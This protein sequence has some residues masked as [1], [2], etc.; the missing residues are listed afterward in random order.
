[1]DIGG[2]SHRKWTRSFSVVFCFLCHLVQR[3][4]FHSPPMLHKVRT[5][6]P[7]KIRAIKIDP[8]PDRIDRLHLSVH[9]TPRVLRKTGAIVI[10]LTPSCGVHGGAPVGIAYERTGAGGARVRPYTARTRHRQAGGMWRGIQAGGY[11]IHHRA[12]YAIRPAARRVREAASLNVP[13][14]GAHARPTTTNDAQATRG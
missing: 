6:Y 9:Q 3:T 10:G 8:Y 12:R 1:M 2:L 4:L 5:P 13:Q 7:D 14:V 11:V